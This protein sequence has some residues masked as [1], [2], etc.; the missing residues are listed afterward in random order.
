VDETRRASDP[1]SVDDVAREFKDARVNELMRI[2]KPP[3]GSDVKAFAEGL[4]LAAE[5]YAMQVRVPSANRIHAEIKKLH[6]AAVR[7]R[8]E[9]A[10]N[11]IE[12]LSSEARYM[13]DSVGTLPLADAFRHPARRKS[14]CES[15][16]S[17]CRVGAGSR[18]GKSDWR[19]QLFAPK[20]RRGHPGRQAER[21]FVE[22]IQLAWARDRQ[23][24]KRS[25]QSESARSF[26]APDPGVPKN[27][28]S[29][30]RERSRNLES[31]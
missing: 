6:G 21:D 14:A 2:G 18:G 15:V 10:A 30:T 9:E 24:T 4:R 7:G 19:R 17:L 16:A 8:S 29:G 11:L 25:G 28:R 31:A 13:L 5:F 26:C 27:H 23:A 12:R 20:A 22:R 3:A 1:I